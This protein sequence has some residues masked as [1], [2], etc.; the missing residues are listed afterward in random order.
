MKKILVLFII[1]IY[2]VPMFAA[3]PGFDDYSL[4]WAMPTQRATG[5][6]LETGD[7]WGYDLMW[8]RIVNDDSCLDPLMETPDN[9]TLERSQAV[10]ACFESIGAPSWEKITPETLVRYSGEFPVGDT[11]AWSVRAIPA[12]PDDLSIKY[13]RKEGEIKDEVWSL[14]S[15]V[16]VKTMEHRFSIGIERI[17]SFEV[18]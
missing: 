8:V 10:L 4:N 18:Q 11:Y 17:A 16:R 3:E 6:P 5:E 12:D 14:W 15:R 7:V 2:N 13:K 9:P 1:A